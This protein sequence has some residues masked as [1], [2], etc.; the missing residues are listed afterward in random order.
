MRS[1]F[2]VMCSGL[3]FNFKSLL[4]DIKKIVYLT[5][6]AMPETTTQE[7]MERASFKRSFLVCSKANKANKVEHL[8]SKQA[9]PDPGTQL[10][11]IE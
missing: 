3:H 6:W 2:V 7:L 4:Q 5:Q 1:N 11:N 10:L 9:L 8:P